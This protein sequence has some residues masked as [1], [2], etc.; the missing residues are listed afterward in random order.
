MAQH[1]LLKCF[2]IGLLYFKRW[3]DSKLYVLKR[4][5]I[6]R[7]KCNGQ[8]ICIGLQ[9]INLYRCEIVRLVAIDTK[10]AYSPISQ[11]NGNRDSAFNSFLMLTCIQA[12]IL[13]A[14]LYHKIMSLLQCVARQRFHPEQL[15]LIEENFFP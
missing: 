4:K 10:A 15:C 3:N 11:Q 2:E 5:K 9:K 8:Y 14:I 13:L 1:A 7:C 12:V 6:F